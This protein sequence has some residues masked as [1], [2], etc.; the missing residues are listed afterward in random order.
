MSTLQGNHFDEFHF[1]IENE[2][3]T[4]NHFIRFKFIYNSQDLH[5]NLCEL[6]NAVSDI[7]YV[8]DRYSLLC[9]FLH[10]IIYDWLNAC[11]NS[12]VLGIINVLVEFNKHYQ[13]SA[14]SFRLRLLD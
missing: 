13:W 6:Y 1:W 8:Y 2:I 12:P 4:L 11:I 9:N 10:T 5:I 7:I 14:I 3:S